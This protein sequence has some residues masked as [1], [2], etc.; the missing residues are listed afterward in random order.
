M[1]RF[2]PALTVG[3]GP[4]RIHILNISDDYIRL[5]LNKEV[6][7]SLFYKEY[8]SITNYALAK[9]ISHHIREFIKV[10]I[11]NAINHFII[12]LMLADKCSQMQKSFNCIVNYV[13]S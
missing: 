13:L 5:S 9:T 10:E 7:S 2:L 4:K 8:C 1:L 11:C 3:C 12:A 6:L